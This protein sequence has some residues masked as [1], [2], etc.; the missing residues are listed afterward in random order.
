MFPFFS[1]ILNMLVSVVKYV[2]TFFK[3]MFIFFAMLSKSIVYLT[4]VIRF[5]PAPLVGAAT[6]IISIS[7][8]YMIIGRK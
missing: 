2:G 3:S 4:T 5:L 1:M 7:V 8:I 6:A